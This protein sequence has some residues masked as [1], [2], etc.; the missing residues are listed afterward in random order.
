MNKGNDPIVGFLDA[1]HLV[2]DKTKN[3][4]K[5]ETVSLFEAVDRV[6]AEDILCVK[7][8]PAFTNSAMDGYGVKVSDGGK[9]VVVK[10]TV[11]AGDNPE[12]VAINDGEAIKI[13][14]GAPVPPSVELVVPFENGIEP[15]DTGV[16]LPDNLKKGANIRKKGEEADMDESLLSAGTVLT[17]S[18]IGMLASQGIFAVTVAA[19]PKVAVISSGNEIVEPW[20]KALEHQIY[21]SNA[22][23]LMALCKQYGS[24]PHYVRLLADTYES[25]V[26]AIKSLSGYDLILTTGGISMGEADYIG[27]AFIDCG[28]SVIFKKIQL[29]PGKPTMFG[30]LGETAVLALPGNPLS[31]IVNFYLFGAPA[32][33]KMQGSKAL[34]PNFVLAKNKIGFEI[35]NSRANVVLGSLRDGEFEVYGQNKYGSGMLKPIAGSNAFI[36]TGENIT[37]VEEGD[38]VKVVLLDSGLIEEFSDFMIN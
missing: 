34:Y 8:L 11:Y 30:Y 24:K 33:A 21:N 35:K 32:I 27:R 15:D 20:D 38:N 7:P 6:L 18:A 3:F 19:K 2:A 29:K 13:M 4:S 36:V 1:L 26:D 23:T 17:P 28:L 22:S 25:T 31:A 5:K 10:Y 9:R 16:T 14:T 12:G 37:K